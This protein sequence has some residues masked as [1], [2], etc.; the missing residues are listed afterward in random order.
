MR[1][2]AIREKE[3]RARLQYERQVEER[4]RRL[5]EQ[6]QREELRRTAVEEKRRQRLEEEKER[7]EALMRRS[8]ERS[9]QLEQRPKRWT[10]G[11]ATGTGPAAREA[12]DTLSASTMS[13]PPHAESPINKRLSSS[14]ATITH[15]AERRRLHLSPL[16]NLLVSR[17]LTPTHSSLAR[18]RSE[19]HLG[20][21]CRLGPPG[22]TATAGYIWTPQP[23]QCAQL[24]LLCFQRETERL[25]K[26]KRPSCPVPGSPMRRVDAPAGMTTS[27]RPASPA[28]P[29][30]VSKTRA[31]SPCTV[32]QYPPSPMRHRATTPGS[33]NGKK[34]SDRG[35][36]AALD[37]RLEEAL[38]TEMPE[39]KLPKSASSDLSAREGGE[40]SAE[41]SP[42]T[43]TG[44]AIAGTTDAEEASRLLAERRR[45]ARL[46][47]ELEE[48]Q[49]REQEEAERVKAEA[50]RIK[51]AEERARQEEEARRA[52]EQRQRQE[53]E[54]RQRE[55]E[56]RRQREREERELQ[57]QLEREREEAEVK[58]QQEAER[59]RQERELLQLQ[60][61]QER[62][63]RKKRIEE[64]MKRTR[65]SDACEKD[66]MRQK[67][68]LCLFVCFK[69]LISPAF[70]E[71]RGEA[72]GA[73][74]WVK[75]RGGPSPPA[76]REALAP[77]LISLQPLDMKSNVDEAVDEVQSMDVSPVSK[78]E[79]VSLPDFSPV[80]EI[81]HNGMS[82][83]KALEDLLDL[84]GHIAYPK[85]GGPPPGL[86][87][88]N[89]NLI[90]GFCT[91]SSETQLIESLAQSVDK[92]NV[93]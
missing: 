1:E 49:R 89:K 69:R 51:M 93:Q 11:G 76:A 32:K 7:L 56:E 85:L 13:L 50:L 30:L 59:L 72:G 77:P 25:K 61:E 71:G 47:K 43:P 67:V 17:L 62:L 64:I 8:L 81:H 66:K 88:C 54:Q 70:T 31:Q 6:R 33:D 4:W 91:S 79:L 55:E 22:N 40:R 2:Q 65:K 29:K 28:T 5:E 27:K 12:T 36:G 19:A 60:G 75:A 73:A 42:V 92:A 9:L 84:T 10:W 23:G 52:E 80:N 3:R 86:G 87:D 90:E 44:K 45:Q 24:L 21:P 74:C 48:R 83:S 26:E 37:R 20:Q 63:Q 18:C 46:Q 68:G 78:E 14:S 15:T 39:K 53:L 38:G 82:N 58:A 16:E 35:E 41:P 57:I 34:K